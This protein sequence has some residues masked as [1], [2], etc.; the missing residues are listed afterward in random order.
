MP[1]FKMRK[2]SSTLSENV[3]SSNNSNKHYGKYL[4]HLGSLLNKVSQHGNLPQQKF[5][6]KSNFKFVYLEKL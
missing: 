5:F 1:V 4:S 3:E 2:P 6:I